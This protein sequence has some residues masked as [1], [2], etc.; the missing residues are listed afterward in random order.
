MNSTFG[1]FAGAAAGSVAGDSQHVAA[2]KNANEERRFMATILTSA[3][4]K[5]SGLQ[6]LS[7]AEPLRDDLTGGAIALQ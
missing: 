6:R 4:G 3:G 7:I 2:I 1:G 5:S